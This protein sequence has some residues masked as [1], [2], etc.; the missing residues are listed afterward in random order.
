MESRDT[1]IAIVGGGLAGGLIALALYRQR[2][3]MRVRLIEAGERLGGN[4]RWSWFASD[5]AGD[6][7]QL[8]EPFAKAT[9]DKGY[10]VRF[11]GLKRRLQAGYRSLTSE[12]YHAGLTDI[13][14]D[15]WI[16]LGCHVATLDADGVTL[17]TGERLSAR[18]V[19]DCRNF[20]PSPHLQGGWQIFVGHAVALPRPHQIDRPVIMDA[21]VPQHDPHGNGSAYRFVYVL[22]LSE[23][24]IFI[25]DTYY[26]DDPLLDRKLLSARVTAYAAENGWDGETV[27]REWGVLP[28]ITGGNFTAYQQSVRIPGV[29]V[30]GARG[31]FSHP[32]TSYTMPI[33]VENALAI[34]RASD[35]PGRHL[36]A[37]CEA[38]AQR[39]WKKTAFYRMLGRMLFGAAIPQERYR[40]FERFYGLDERLIERF[41]AGKST[42]ADKARVLIGKPPVSISRAIRALSTDGAAL[43]QEKT[44]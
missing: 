39:H 27:G 32:L 30:A 2:P 17:E 11:P 33:A 24:E 7:A 34:A 41:Y 12:D 20:A 35:L 28:V 37:F 18:S 25:E 6:A 9:W 16:R 29:A 36:A 22:P 5:L 1:D 23:R 40:V 13:L 42:S 38:R 44:A 19:I 26:A 43:T 4:H 14:P 10:D 3:E 15:D 21:T 8:M 31:G